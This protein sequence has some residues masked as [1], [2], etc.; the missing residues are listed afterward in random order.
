MEEQV[1][2]ELESV[3]N[4]YWVELDKALKRLLKSEDFKRVILEGYLKEKALSGVSLLGRSDVKKRGERP[5]VI[6]ELVSVANLQQYLFT[7][8]PSLAGS[9]LAEENR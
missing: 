4:S 5:D 9:A 2:N 1:L 6:E 3:D 8:I 7:V